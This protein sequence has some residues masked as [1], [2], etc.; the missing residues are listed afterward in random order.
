MWLKQQNYY[1]FHMPT[2]GKLLATFISKKKLQFHSDSEVQ[3]TI[4]F[5]KECKDPKTVNK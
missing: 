3:E 1:L 4:D 2:D 5:I